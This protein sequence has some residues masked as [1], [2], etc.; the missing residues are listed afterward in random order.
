MY[1]NLELPATATTDQVIARVFDMTGFEEGHVTRYR[2]LETRQVQIGSRPDMYTAA[3]VQTDL[4][5]KVVLLKYES[6]ATRWWSRVY[7]SE[8]S[9]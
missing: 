8:P 1:P 7:D 2:V 5:N 3:V 4:G 9:A 6:A